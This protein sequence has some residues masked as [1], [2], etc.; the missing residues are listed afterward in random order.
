MSPNKF[1]HWFV[2][3][4]MY[5]NFWT[6]QIKTRFR[7]SV[8]HPVLLSYS[9]SGGAK[10][11]MQWNWREQIWVHMIFKIKPIPLPISIDLFIIVPLLWQFFLFDICTWCR[12]D[13]SA[14]FLRP[15]KVSIDCYDYHFRTIIA[16]NSA[17]YLCKMMDPSLVPAYL[18]GT[19]KDP[20]TRCT[21]FVS[22]LDHIPHNLGTGLFNLS[23]IIAFWKDQNLNL[24]MSDSGKIYWIE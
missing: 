2:L 19:R 4:N 15:L 21:N 22:T 24:K 6:A 16:D 10:T 12:A 3:K 13:Y 9:W 1:I 20:D 17:D 5:Q 18:G 11:W 8:Y 14:I 7:N 23:L